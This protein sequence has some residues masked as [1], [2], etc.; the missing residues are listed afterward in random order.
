M[1]LP[2]PI[3]LEEARDR[4]LALAPLLPVE[5]VDAEGCLGR[6]LAQSLH[7]RRTH[8]PT[9]L[10][11][12][13]G[14]AV[15]AGD[16]SGPWRVVGESAAGH[17]YSGTVHSGEAVRISTGAILPMGAKAVILQEDLAREA[18]NLTLTGEPPEPADRH[19]RHCGMDFFENSE[20][21][22]A[23]IRIGP[24]QAALAIACGYRHLPVR[25][26]PR[27]AVIDIGDELAADPEC[28]APHQIP[29]SNGAM[30]MALAR[31][32]PIAASRIGPVADTLAALTA[33]FEGAADSDVIVTSGGASVGDHDLV[34]PALEGWGANLDFWRVAIKPG[35]PILVATRERNGRIQ[36]ILGLPG[37][38]V[39]SFVTA[40][41]F[42][43]PLLR[44]MLG[45]SQ[46]TPLQ[47]ATYLA[48]PL[49]ANGPRREFLR[50]N[51]DGEN[52]VPQTNQDSGAL[53]ALAASNVL[54]DRPSFAPAAQV[55]DP[56]RVFLLEN[57]G[58]A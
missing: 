45:S 50:G 31:S 40:Y 27:L 7:A 2:P 36:I 56:V 54:I 28:C 38:P 17:P 13:D 23:G 1:S 21:M 14:Y 22:P 9:D 10:S 49:R 52:V 30:L 55:G 34:L 4:L 18:A 26:I 53:A 47:I 29:A 12:M 44:R 16:L 37:N 8:P 48:A 42:L 24:A 46:A 3:T 32:L 41:H 15:T 19:I 6:Y 20:V 33:A 39:S 51:W 35:K 25:R 5:H 58:I 11:A 43:M 57:G